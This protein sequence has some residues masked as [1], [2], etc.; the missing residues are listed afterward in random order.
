MRFHVTGQFGVGHGTPFN[1]HVGLG[2]ADEKKGSA[3][4]ER[5]KNSILVWVSVVFNSDVFG[6]IQ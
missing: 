1:A 2:N 5:R 3:A 6:P 4:T